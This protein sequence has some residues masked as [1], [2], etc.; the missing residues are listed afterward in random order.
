MSAHLL[1]TTTPTKENTVYFDDNT[2]LLS[3]VR[4]TVLSGL[5]TLHELNADVALL[6]SQGETLWLSEKSQDDF[7][8]ADLLLGEMSQNAQERLFASPIEL[9]GKFYYLAPIYSQFGELQ[10]ILALSTAQINSNILLALLQSLGREASEKLK[11]QSYRQPASLRPF[12]APNIAELNI[13]SVEKALI[14][15][16]AK[17]CRGKIQQMHQIL[18]MGRTTLWRKLKQYDINIKEYK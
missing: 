16:V 6:S 12:Q 5:S 7:E 2:L 3:L 11:C 17:T 10:L 13:Q 4:D 9:H 14:I 1:F 18:N 15:E 8:I